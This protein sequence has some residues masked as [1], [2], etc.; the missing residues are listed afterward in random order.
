MWNS[1]LHLATSRLRSSYAF[2]K[3]TK[4]N[5]GNQ[6]PLSNRTDLCPDHALRTMIWFLDADNIRPTLSQPAFRNKLAFAMM[7]DA[8][9]NNAPAGAIN[10]HSLKKG[11]APAL[12]AACVDWATIQRLGRWRGLI[13]HEYVARLCRFP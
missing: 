12:F 6:N 7:W 2:R 9:P 13:F 8:L 1:Y 4:R 5:G 3:P 11:G 10:T